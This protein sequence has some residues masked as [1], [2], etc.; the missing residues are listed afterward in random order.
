MLEFHPVSLADREWAADRMRCTGFRGSDYTF[1][2]LYNW[3]EVYQICIAKMN[4]YLIIRSGEG[5]FGY[6]FPAG[7]GDVR[8]VIDA[9]AQ[10]SAR[11]G[12]SLLLYN[13]PRQ[14]VD[15]LE[16]LWPG[17]F[18]FREERNNF[19]YIYTRESLMTLAGKKLHGKRNHIARFKDNNPDW[20]Y[21]P[22][23][24]ENLTE[25][26]AMN[27]EW[28]RQND[29]PNSHSLQKEACAVRR[30]FENFE[31]EGLVGGLLRAGGRVVAYTM[32][33]PVTADTFVVHIEKAFAEI[34]GAYPM[35]NQQ[36]VTHALEGY[37]Y[38]NREDDVGDLGLRKAKLSY[39]PT[40]LYERF[41]A[42]EKEKA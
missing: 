4:D 29:C 40:M 5:P 25:A 20:S 23:T 39:Q 38:V 11:Q 16:D 34:Q 7:E 26:R 32:G 41:E 21:E 19:D 22:L 30:A 8:P 1:A 24:P 15:T 36:F 10:D 12:H 9:I 31:A 42:F 17:R 2:N 37:T 35:I 33:S 14:A 13:L 6:L 27:T 18:S 28:C 3:A